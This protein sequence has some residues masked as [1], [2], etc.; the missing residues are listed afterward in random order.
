MVRGLAT[1]RAKPAKM[2]A[3]ERA[4]RDAAAP[5]R[6]QAGCLWFEAYRPAQ[7]P[8]AITAIEGWVSPPEIVAMR[9]L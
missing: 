1:A 9:P 5:T 2:A 6:A 8:A 4:L 7:N 3:L